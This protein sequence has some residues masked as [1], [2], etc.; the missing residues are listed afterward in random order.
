[1][2]KITKRTFALLVAAVSCSAALSGCGEKEQETSVVDFEFESYPI[3]TDATLTYWMELNG[4]VA[5]LSEDFGK[6]PLAIKL[7]EETGVDVKYIHPPQGQAKDQLNILLASEELPDII[8]YSWTN[9][10]GGPSKALADDFI[11]D[12]T[13]VFAKSAPNLMK[14]LNENPDVDK[15]IKTDDNRYYAFPFLKNDEKLLVVQGL[16]IRQD[17]LDELGLAM[18]ETIDEWHNVLTQFKEKKGAS[19]PLSYQ[20]NMLTNGDFIG[21]Y[22]IKKGFFAEDGKIVYG[23]YDHR[24]KEFLTTFAQWYKEG[25]IDQNISNLDSKTL[26]ANILNGKTGVTFGFAGSALGRWMQ[27]FAEKDPKAN[28]MPAPHV[29][30]N[31]G[32]MSKFGQ[33]DFKA[34]SYGTAITSSCKNVDLAARFLDYGYSEA[35]YKLYNFGIEGESYN[36]ID[37]YPTYTDYIMKNPEGLSV[38]A[39]M[40]QYIRGNQNGPFIQAK[41]YIEQYYTTP[42]Q[43]AAL[44]VWAKSEAEKYNLPYLNFTTEESSEVATILNNIQTHVDEKTA[45]Y[46]MGLE[47]LSTFDAYLGELK[48]FDIDR[49]LEIYQ[50]AYDRYLNK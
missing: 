47:D 39:A 28:L 8:E 46:I 31:K 11:I 45:R 19:S 40:G 15:L 29:T 20:D 9:L 6:T 42:Q 43:S 24:Y 13:D 30:L 32:E 50:A 4:N 7:K 10:A 12:H 26:D 3:Q 48:G 36:M 38:G 5:T 21:A 34:S 22:G 27:A 18:P 23:P 16:V 33:K 44:D 41:E 49:L 2:K 25:L 37:N 35:G 14:Y 17:W 1:M